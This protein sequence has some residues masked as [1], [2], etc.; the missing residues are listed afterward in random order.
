MPVRNGPL[1]AFHG[2]LII[3][4][5][6]VV[7]YFGL[8]GCL[9]GSFSFF[10]SQ[11]EFNYFVMYFTELIIKVCDVESYTVIQYPMMS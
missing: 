2:T 6:Y 10:I 4:K 3:K 9:D 11:V 5:P 8:S 1:C 7:A